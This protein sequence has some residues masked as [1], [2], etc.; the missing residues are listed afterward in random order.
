MRHG[1][2]GIPNIGGPPV[3]GR[4]ISPPI[5]MPIM[6]APPVAGK[7]TRGIMFWS[8]DGARF[9]CGVGADTSVFRVLAVSAR[10]SADDPVVAQAANAKVATSPGKSVF[11]VS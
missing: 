10:L 11:M 4:N 5:G 6:G 9:G 2:V 1:E 7:M 3:A 8:F